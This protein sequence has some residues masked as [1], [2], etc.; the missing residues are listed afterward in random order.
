MNLPDLKSL[1]LGEVWQRIREVIADPS[2]N[3]TAA[4]LMITVASLVALIIIT[5]IVLL[6]SA[7]AGSFFGDD[8][9]EDEDDE[10]E[11]ED[12]DEDVSTEPSR[13]SRFL[14]A[15]TT[16]FLRVAI[17]LLLV[18]LIGSA[19]YAYRA[20]GKRSFCASTC[21]ETT[22][23]VKSSSKDA[24]KS[25]SCV[26]CHEGGVVDAAVQRVGHVGARY[27]G[28]ETQVRPVP[29]SRCLSC[30][31]NVADGVT[32]NRTRGIKMSHA[33]PLEA[34]MSCD[35]CHRRIG[36]GTDSAPG[37]NACLRCH[38]VGEVSAKCAVCHVGDTAQAAVSRYVFPRIRAANRECGGCHDLRP[39][40]ACHGLRMPHGVAFVE[41]DHAR[42][43]VFD[44]KRVCLKCHDDLAMCGQ[45][46]GS[47][48]KGGHN[49][50]WQTRTTHAQYFPAPMLREKTVACGCH[51]RAGIRYE[52]FCALCHDNAGGPLIAPSTEAST[53]GTGT[54]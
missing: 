26:A 34:G 54:P 31:D 30:H 19:V 49:P 48:D 18:G 22:S 1:Q 27:L 16:I 35:D 25:V 3:L 15:S 20:T 8:E 37:M 28:V 45:C 2:S 36:H 51:Q 21:H 17:A 24:H 7:T 52:N 11:D 39:C 43:A 42:E 6:L 9:D 32:L 4:V 41:R 50:G 33:E 44:G 5:F 29:S 14:E 12:A 23:V 47:F 10:D 53:T 46:H 40:D 38:G 13:F